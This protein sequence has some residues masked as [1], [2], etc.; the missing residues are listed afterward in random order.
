MSEMK[1]GYAVGTCSK[2]KK[3]HRKPR[4]VDVAYCNCWKFCPLCGTEMADYVPDTSGETSYN[5]EMGMHAVKY[6]SICDRY[7]KQLPV[8]VALE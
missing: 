4:P 2:C 6:C 7:S 8:E 1:A 3:E 5:P